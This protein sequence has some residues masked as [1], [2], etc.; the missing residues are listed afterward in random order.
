MIPSF[1]GEFINY[2]VLII[3]NF[4]KKC[5]KRALEANVQKRSPFFWNTLQFCKKSIDASR[6]PYTDLAK[7]FQASLNQ[8]PSTIILS[9][10]R[11]GDYS[12]SMYD[13]FRYSRNFHQWVANNFGNRCAHLYRENIVLFFCF[14]KTIL[15]FNFFRVSICS[16]EMKASYNIGKNIFFVDHSHFT[17]CRSLA[18]TSGLLKI[19]RFDFKKLSVTYNHGKN[20]RKYI[21]IQS[22][23]SIIVKHFIQSKL[24]Y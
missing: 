15:K 1:F 3:S 19:I 5:L 8:G 17:F 9:C 14:M 11:H 2:M 4:W 13:K 20:I 24:V 18:V 10:H 6:R 7:N 16:I 23:C 12:I 21:K 22:K